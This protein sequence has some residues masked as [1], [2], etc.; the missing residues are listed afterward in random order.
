[1]FLLCLLIILSATV[2]SLAY[3]ENVSQL[4]L[5]STYTNTTPSFS[6][7]D[8][9]F[10]QDATNNIILIDFKAIQAQLTNIQIKQLNKIVLN[11]QVND[12]SPNI[13]YEVDLMKYG[14][15][16]YT[17]ILTTSQQK[18]ITKQFSVK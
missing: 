1:M 8:R 7:T 4:G 10:Y 18:T 12:L 6:A 9:I 14:Q 15:G 3:S 16:E 2:F 13:M 11:D 17:I 5:Q